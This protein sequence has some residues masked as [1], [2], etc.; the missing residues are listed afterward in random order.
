MRATVAGT[1]LILVL[2]RNALAGGKEQATATA[3]AGGRMT[4]LTKEVFLRHRNQRPPATGFVTY[5]HKSKP[6]LMHCHGWEDYSDGYDDFSVTLSY[7]NGKTWS[8]EEMRW[9]SKVVPEGR[10][11]YAE[12]AAFFDP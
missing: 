11:R 5:I 3:T 12:P 2:A 7:D 4:L 10:L 9:Q 6:V 8:A 1:V